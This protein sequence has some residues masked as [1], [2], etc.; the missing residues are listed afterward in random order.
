MAMTPNS[1]MLTFPPFFACVLLRHMRAIS[2]CLDFIGGV[3]G[4]PE[5]MNPGFKGSQCVRSAS[6]CSKKFLPTSIGLG[7][8][9]PSDVLGSSSSDEMSSHTAA[10]AFLRSLIGLLL[11]P[12]S[13][14]PAQSLIVPPLVPFSAAGEV[15]LEGPDS[16]RS[17]STASAKAAA[18]AGSEPSRPNA[19]F[20]S[21]DIVEVSMPMLRKSASDGRDFGDLAGDDLTTAAP[22]PGA[23]FMPIPAM[24][25]SSACFMPIPAMKPSSNC[26][27]S[28]ARGRAWYSD[29]GFTMDATS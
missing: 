22:G 29:G 4:A 12:V 15:C 18:F 25:S 24:K 10:A 2:A 8:H 28:G 26:L 20:S 17:R 27:G 6:C 13:L 3:G 11:V 16:I 23:C 1:F 5:V 9:R 19:L 14:P 21:A 7:F